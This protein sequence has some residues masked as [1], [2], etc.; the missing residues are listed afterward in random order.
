L[1]F[2]TCTNNNIL[3]K[4]SVVGCQVGDMN[5]NLN[6]YRTGTNSNTLDTTSYENIVAGVSNLTAASVHQSVA[7]GLNNAANSSRCLSFG[8][9][10]LC[11][12]VDSAVVGARGRAPY[13]GSFAVANSRVPQ[14]GAQQLFWVWSART[15]S[16]AT[17]RATADGTASYVDSN[18]F[19]LDLFGTIAAATF[20]NITITAKD[21]T[22][23]QIAGT[24]TTSGT[25]NWTGG[26]AAWLGGAIGSTGSLTGSTATIAAD[27]AN[28]GG[29]NIQINPPSSDTIVWTISFTSIVTEGY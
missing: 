17:F 12:A 29:L 15:T 23:N 18:I 1:G 4:Y 19:G 14:G 10:N 11:N 3:G 20:T 7:V 16:N 8:S 28:G 26:T 5:I 27:S 13:V 25:L 21:V 22:T 24:W 2:N 9:N 6:Q